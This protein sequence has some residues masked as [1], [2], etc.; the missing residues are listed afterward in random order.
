MQNLPPSW[1]LLF[2][3]FH[4]H[5]DW[6]RGGLLF[7]SRS[8]HCHSVYLLM[9]VVQGSFQEFLEGHW[10]KID[11]FQIEHGCCI[12]IVQYYS[13]II[14]FVI[15]VFLEVADRIKKKSIRCERRIFH[16]CVCG[17]ILKGCFCLFL[18]Y[19]YPISGFSGTAT[20]LPR[21]Q[22][23]LHLRFYCLWCGYWSNFSM[24]FSRAQLCLWK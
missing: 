3:K 4:T 23:L 5:L 9:I 20:R 21:N 19:C 14:V 7:I 16:G 18:V 6:S 24:V 2:D 13:S 22:C 1:P 17:P 11:L 12:V 8:S 15:M 10:S